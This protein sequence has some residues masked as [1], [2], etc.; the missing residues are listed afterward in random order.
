M[1]AEGLIRIID[2]NGRIVH[3][4][5]RLLDAGTNTISIQGLDQLSVGTYLLELRFGN[6]RTARKMFKI[7]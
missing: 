6:E 1:Y 5:Y 3:N 4:S 7:N 2:Q